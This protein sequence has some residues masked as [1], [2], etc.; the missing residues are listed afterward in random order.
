[1]WAGFVGNCSAGPPYRQ[2]LP[3]RRPMWPAEATRQC[4]RTNVVHTWRRSGDFQPCCESCSQ[5]PTLLYQRRA[6]CIASTLV[7]FESCGL[8]PMRSPKILCIC[9]SSALWTGY[10]NLPRQ[11]WTDAAARD[12]SRRALNLM[13]SILSTLSAVPHE[14]DV[15]GHTLFGV[16]NSCQKFVHIFQLD[17]LRVYCSCVRGT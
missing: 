14:S 13:D 15:S 7:R 1:M 9:S 6:H 5:W 8:L 10:P 17:P 16:W 4:Q 3:K 12:V 11:L 2:P